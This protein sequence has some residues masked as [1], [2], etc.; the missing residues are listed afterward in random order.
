MEGQ[1]A[2]A[3][4]PGV[5]LQYSVNREQPPSD[6]GSGLLAGQ[7]VQTRQPPPSRVLHRL[8][9]G[10]IPSGSRCRG[11]RKGYYR[12]A[13]RRASPVQPYQPGWAALPNGG[14]EK[15]RRRY[16]SGRLPPGE[17]IGGKAT[18]ALPPPKQRL[19]RAA[20]APC[21]PAHSRLGKCTE[22]QRTPS[23][24][25]PGATGPTP[26]DPGGSGVL[27]LSKERKHG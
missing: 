19:C 12:A 3:D 21:V 14:P 5:V 18:A 6:P 13:P 2:S 8:Q 15:P 20:G 27:P 16:P 26:P 4:N 22:R 9:M 17:G 11:H 1:S 25:G 10:P 24:F 23:G 7:F